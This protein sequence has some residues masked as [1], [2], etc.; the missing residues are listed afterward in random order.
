LP[1]CEETPQQPI[2][3]YGASTGRARAALNALR[4]GLAVSVFGDIVWG[5]QVEVLARRIAGERADAE[6]LEAASAVAAAQIELN[7]MHTN[8]R[9]AIE[10]AVVENE[11]AAELQPC[12]FQ[13][14][15]GN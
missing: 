8:R 10:Q 4:H 11:R 15:P 13:V 1:I 2:N 6:L 14:S 7:R 3:P 12:A 5:P 9:R